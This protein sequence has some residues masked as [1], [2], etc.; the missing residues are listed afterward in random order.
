MVLRIGRKWSQSKSFNP[1]KYSLANQTQQLKFKTAKVQQ[2]CRHSI[3][4][5]STWPIET[6]RIFFW[7]GQSN[8]SK[9]HHKRVRPQ[10]YGNL[11]HT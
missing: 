5:K 8:M 4:L 9:L 11:H 1:N 7:L 2:I 10:I 3:E 6:Q